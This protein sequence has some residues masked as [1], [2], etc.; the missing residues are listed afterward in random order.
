MQ[1][2]KENPEEF[3]EEASFRIVKIAVPVVLTLILDAILTRLLENT[4]GSVSLDRS[5][6][7]TLSYNSAGLS[8]EWSIYLALILIAAI[9]I[10]TAILLVCYYYGF[11]K[12]IFVWMVLAVSIILSYYVWMYVGRIPALLNFPV[13]YITFIILIINLVVVGDLSIFWRAP[14][15]VTQIFL[16][17]ISVLIA[18]V[19]LTFPDWTIW[20]LLVILVIYDCC[21][22]L[23]PHG[24]LNMLIKKSEERNDEIPA[25]VYASAAYHMGE[26][27]HWNEYEGWEAAQEE[28]DEAQSE[29]DSQ[30]GMEGDSSDDEKT[31]KKTRAEDQDDDDEETTND[32]RDKEAAKKEDAENPQQKKQHK[33]AHKKKKVRDGVRLG[34]GD[35]CFYGILITRAARL[36]WDLTILCIFAV[37]LGLSLTLLLLA[38][39]QRPLPALPISLILGIIF[40]VIGALTFRKFDIN[41]R[42]TL[43]AF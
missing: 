25:L 32:N 41:L 11:T 38:W 13:D 12:V 2:D 15:I 18:L 23:C 7:E 4:R 40:F 10:V 30:D 24:L 14:P 28:Q 36:G 37:I 22:V 26:D 34:L 16:V 8:T 29:D 21:V 35:F 5:F 33:T 17:F 39:L 31:S 20:I 3:L 43:L 27:H 42:D 1:I 19:F 9:I 6:S